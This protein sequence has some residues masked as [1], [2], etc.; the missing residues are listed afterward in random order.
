MMDLMVYGIQV[1]LKTIM[2][3]NNS[4]VAYRYD[5]RRKNLRCINDP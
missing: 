1:K 5:Y 2:F 3:G 4:R